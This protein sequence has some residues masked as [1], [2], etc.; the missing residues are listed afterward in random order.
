MKRNNKLLSRVLMLAQP[1]LLLTSCAHEL[2]NSFPQV[3]PP[4]IPP[5]PVQARVSLVETPLM[6]L[7]TCSAGLTRLRDSLANTPTDSR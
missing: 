3:V 6:C 4:Q 7:S 5:L 1:V 2:P